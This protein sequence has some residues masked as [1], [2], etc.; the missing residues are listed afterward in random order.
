MP[1]ENFYVRKEYGAKTRGNTYG[2]GRHSECITCWKLRVKENIA[3]N[4]ERRKE[5]DRIR[6]QKKKIAKQKDERLK[7]AKERY[8]RNQG[9]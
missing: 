6:Y 9:L 8:L 5:L 2:D 4:P 7:K 3:K 1:L